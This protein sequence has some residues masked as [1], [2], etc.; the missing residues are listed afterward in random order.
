[1]N[2]E[3][4]EVKELSSFRS[5]GEAFRAGFTEPVESREMTEGQALRADTNEQPVVKL[6]DT[7][8]ILG[9]RRHSAMKKRGSNYTPPKKKRKKRR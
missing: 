1:M 2:P 8:S 3:T 5:L 6:K 4:G 9:K 7:R